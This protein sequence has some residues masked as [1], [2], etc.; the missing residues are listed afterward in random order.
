MSTCKV[1]QQRESE[2]RIS[3]VLSGKVAEFDELR[4]CF[5]APAGTRQFSRVVTVSSGKIP[6]LRRAAR[7]DACRPSPG[8]ADSRGVDKLELLR[9][10]AA[11]CRRKSANTGGGG[12]GNPN[13]RACPRRMGC[14]PGRLRQRPDSARGERVPHPPELQG[15]L[16]RPQG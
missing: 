6:G 8:R 16:L 7:R 5:L 13:G 14:K 15:R 9:S 12:Q 4:S 1:A 3:G 2:C 11:S 10:E